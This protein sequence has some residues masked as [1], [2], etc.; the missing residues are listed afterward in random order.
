MKWRGDLHQLQAS[1]ERSRRKNIAQR[2]KALDWLSD[3][4]SDLK[5]GHAKTIVIE[6]L[7]DGTFVVNKEQLA[8]EEESDD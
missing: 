4:T 6:R 2:R 8:L 7:H 3:A 5:N 1:A